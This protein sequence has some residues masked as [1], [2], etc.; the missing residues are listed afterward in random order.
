MKLSACTTGVALFVSSALGY[1]VRTF[2]DF[3]CKGENRVINVWDNTCRNTD[4][5]SATRS[6]EVV[7]YGGNR[8]R[9]HFYYDTNCFA[10]SN[11]D[12]WAD[13]GSDTFKKG[14]C[15]DMGTEIHAFGSQAI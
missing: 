7:S 8:Q 4:I 15:I 12:W 1:E 10:Y 6:I 9:A 5:L 3:G 2:R 14:R 11:R 13:G